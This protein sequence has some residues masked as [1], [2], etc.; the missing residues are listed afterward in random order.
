[1]ENLE[2]FR[3]SEAARYLRVSVSQLWNFIKAGKIKTVKLSKQVTII[4]KAD[5][6]RFIDHQ[7]DEVA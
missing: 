1:M 2:N 7:A 3:P 6:D 5:L 4:R